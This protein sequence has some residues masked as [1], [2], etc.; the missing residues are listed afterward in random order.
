MTHRLLA[1]L[2]VGLGVLLVAAIV[3]LVYQPALT[4]PFVLDDWAHLE[5]L[6]SLPPDPAAAWQ[7]I[8]GSNSGPTG[9]P[10]A[11]ATFVGDAL[12]HDFR[13]VWTRS[14]NLGLHLATGWV[15]F[16]A[17]RLWL[18]RWFPNPGERRTAIGLAGIAMVLWLVHP[19]NLTSVA[20]LIQ[21]MNQ[22]SALFVAL[23]VLLYSWERTRQQWRPGR[24]IPVLLGLG[25][26]GLLG[27]LSKENAA[28]LPVY[29]LVIEGLVF[30]GAART[31][32]DRRFVVGLFL[33]IL[34][35]PAVL[36]GGWLL[37]DGGRFTDYAIPYTPVE[38]LLTEPRALAWYLQMLLVPNIGAMSLF[39]DGFAHSTGWWSPP[40]T[41]MAMGFW[42]GLILAASI[43]WRRWPWLAFA[44]AW[45]LG[46]HLMESTF[47]PL[48]LVY[49]HRNYLPGFGILL[50][51]V[52]AVHT[53][54]AR[55]PNGHRLGFG[56]AVLALVVLAGSTHIR[57]YRWSDDP[58]ARLTGL[59]QQR[60]SPRANILAAGIYNRLA[61]RVEHVTHRDELIGRGVEHLRR[62]SRLE[63]R[64]PNAFFIWYMIAERHETPNRASVRQ[65][66][67]ER[68][69][70]GRIDKIS[71]NGLHKLA[72]CSIE[73]PCR[74]EPF[75]A[76]VRAALA[77]PGIGD[78]TASRFRRDLARFLAQQA[79]D[80]GGAV[81][82]ARQ[83][84][85]QQPNDLNP[86]I[87]L[88]NYLILAGQLDAA[89]QRLKRLRAADP[90]NRHAADR[91]QLQALL[92]AQRRAERG[93]SS[94]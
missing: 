38:R 10:V 76:I 58:F 84:V 20:Y 71:V 33:T 15:L 35:L 64:S 9:R 24:W 8:W 7:A 11:M 16:L 43:L 62:A 89:Q 69:E 74:A 68:L 66:L 54:L 47:L 27:V 2:G 12:V 31:V 25:A 19:L 17:A 23:A 83:A 81:Q 67:M 72:R 50:G 87:E 39:H 21:R 28:L 45:F 41:A 78:G 49:E 56:V 42:A 77:N 73:G 65:R 53:L 59:T 32:G 34:A 5:E 36:I 46:G 94:P 1:Y 52:V 60:D 30:R 37:L 61:Q 6:R 13:P 75:P 14:V 90:L 48:E 82:Q 4:G 51:A 22:L 18:L 79:G 86:R 29:L 57:A 80:F 92:E 3:G 40:A 26:C 88:T 63:P 85:E 70:T 91:A 93:P 55:A 44:V